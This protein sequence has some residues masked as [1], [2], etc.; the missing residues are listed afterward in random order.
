[1]IKITITMI[2]FVRLRGSNSPFSL[3]PF[4]SSLSPLSLLALPGLVTPLSLH[5][6]HPVSKNAIHL[7]KRTNP[8]P[9]S[10]ESYET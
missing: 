5:I 10:Q 9:E 4:A 2:Y 1:M 7:P 8:K 3:Q 6:F